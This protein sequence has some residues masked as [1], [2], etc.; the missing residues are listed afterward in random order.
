MSAKDVNKVVDELIA[1]QK[2][3][4]T[5][6]REVGEQIVRDAINIKTIEHAKQF[7]ANWIATAAQES[8][9]TEYMTGE[10]D[11]LLA[12]TKAVTSDLPDSKMTS[13]QVTFR[14]EVKSILN[15]QFGS[16]DVLRERLKEV[17]AHWS[18]TTEQLAET[19]DRLS[20]EKIAHDETRGYRQHAEMQLTDVRKDLA[21]LLRDLDDAMGD[22]DP[23]ASYWNGLRDK[24]VKIVGA[25]S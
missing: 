1:K 18:A 5:Q 17:R 25:K 9:N 24:L 12:L 13:E 7:A 14:A 22:V 8:R 3:L 11:R 2:R 4:D 16:P 19:S 15:A 20:A 6:D 21:L 10:R 23:G